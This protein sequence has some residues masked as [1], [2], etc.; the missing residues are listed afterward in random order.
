MERFLVSAATGTMN[1]LLGKLGT[2]LNNEYKLLKGVRDDI[3]FLKRELEAMAAFLLRMADM[4]EPNP[5]SQLHADD[6]RE[7]SYDIEDKIDKFMLLVN[8]ESS[9]QSESFKELLN[10]C[11]KKIADIKTRH[12]IAKDVKDIK[13]QVKELAERHAR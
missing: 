6:V 9:S 13:S 8:H 11:M 7:L 3:K 10:K 1:S 12:K 4:E 2:I 5:Q